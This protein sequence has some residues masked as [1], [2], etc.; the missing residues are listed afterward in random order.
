MLYHT[1]ILVAA[2]NRNQEFGESIKRARGKKRWTQEQLSAAL[3]VHVNTIR[4]Y[5]QGRSSPDLD[6]IEKIAAALEEDHLK[7]GDQMRI[8]FGPNGRPRLQPV[9]YQL[10]L[11]FDDKNGLNIRIES[12]E[13]GLTIKKMS[14]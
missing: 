13:H 9:P 11:Q 4:S 12:A 8:E 5:E 14:A 1:Q 10:T 2:M 7:V 3:G 6:E